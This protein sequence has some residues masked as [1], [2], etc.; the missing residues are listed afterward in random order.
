MRDFMLACAEIVRERGKD[1]VPMSSLAISFGLVWHSLSESEA[2]EFFEDLASWYAGT[3][4]TG[5]VQM[6]TTP[7]RDRRF[8]RWF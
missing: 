4:S 5:A 2:A 1:S 8:R 7:R 6:P 3:S